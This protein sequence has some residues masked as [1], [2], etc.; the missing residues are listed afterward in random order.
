[1]TIECDVLQ[2]CN[3][4]RSLR[5][6]GLLVVRLHERQ[7]E[8]PPCARVGRGMS[9][10]FRIARN[11]IICQD[12]LWTNARTIDICQRSKWVGRFDTQD[13]GEPVGGAACRETGEDTGVFE[14]EWTGGATVQWDCAAGH[15]KITRKP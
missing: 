3:C 1:M 13:F 5:N 15:G 2:L 4:D 8:P 11:P 12:R 6:T 9:P 7:R 10:H 14:R